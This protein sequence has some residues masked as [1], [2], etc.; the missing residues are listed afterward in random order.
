MTMTPIDRRTAHAL[1]KE[2]ITNNLNHGISG[3]LTEGLT[4]DA[5]RD[6]IRNAHTFRHETGTSVEALHIRT[7]P[8]GGWLI[9]YL[10]RDKPPVDPWAP[11]R[12]VTALGI[13]IDTTPAADPAGVKER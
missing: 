5:A 10:N 12:W 9:L 13:E 11:G 1:V 2:T 4:P 8:G 7:R 6:L 3:P